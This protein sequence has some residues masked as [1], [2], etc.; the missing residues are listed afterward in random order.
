M[1]YTNVP[2]TLKWNATNQISAYFFFFLVHFNSLREDGNICNAKFA[3]S[4]TRNIIPI[5]QAIIDDSNQTISFI[6]IALSSIWDLDRQV[7]IMGSFNDHGGKVRR[8]PEEPRERFG[9]LIRVWSEAEFVFRVE[10]ATDVGKDCRR[11]E[12]TSNMPGGKGMC[13]SRDF[14]ILKDEII[15]FNDCFPRV[16][17]GGE[18][19]ILTGLIC[20]Y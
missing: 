16:K 1:P 17:W 13:N 3:P 7:I 6:L 5:L 8:T 19:G 18:G 2:R 9:V 14:V 4:G 15:F 20:K 11:L 12:N 10:F